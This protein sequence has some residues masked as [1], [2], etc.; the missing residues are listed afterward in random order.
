MA[1][2]GKV[3]S[4]AAMKA[5]SYG[6]HG[7]PGRGAVEPLEGFSH[8]VFEV[9]DL[10]RSERWY[11]EIVGLDLVGRDLLAEPHPH[12]VLRMNT[13]QL[14]VLIQV[15]EPEP[16]RPNSSSIHHALLLTMEEYR[17]ALARFQAAGYDISDSRRQFRARGEYST[18]IFDP[19]GHRWQVQAYSD[20]AHELFKPGVGVVDCGPVERYA[21]GSVT[22]FGEGNFFLIREPAGFLALSRWCR[23][24]NGKLAYQPE[25]WRFWCSFHGATYNLE[26]DHIGHLPNIP[27]LRMNPVTITGEGRVLVDTDV[28]IERDDGE[29]PTSTPVPR[30]LSSPAAVGRGG[31]VDG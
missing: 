14:L 22:T 4:K 23:H 6:G 31:P 2:A 30:D 25:H 15:D 8:L 11:R 17:E 19:D 12:S 9:A 26:G 5:P 29:R 13:G 7:M 18:D 16:I 28:V 27:P 20:E 10:D 3:S 21:V 1:S 24:M